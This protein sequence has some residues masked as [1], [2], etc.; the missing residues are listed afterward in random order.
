MKEGIVYRKIKRD[1]ISGGFSEF[2]KTEYIYGGQ[3]ILARRKKK[4]VG[5][6][7]SKL[8]HKDKLLEDGLI[9]DFTPIMVRM[10]VHP[11]LACLSNK[12]V[13]YYDLLNNEQV[14]SL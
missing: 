6:I 12:K 2:F 13:S 10:R 5:V 11:Y 14:A 1:L 3:V 4:V 9:R 8:D 7:F